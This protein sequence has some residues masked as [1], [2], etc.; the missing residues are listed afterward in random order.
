MS[1]VL[2]QSYEVQ[3]PLPFSFIKRINPGLITGFPDLR[4]R[5]K[6]KIVDSCS[7]IIMG[8]MSTLL[9]IVLPDFF[10]LGLQPPFCEYSSLIIEEIEG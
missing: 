8:S 6:C 5:E 3:V 7:Q 1:S 2:Q 4:L 9:L 10:L